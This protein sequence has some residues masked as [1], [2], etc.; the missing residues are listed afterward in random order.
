MLVKSRSQRATAELFIAH[1]ERS[2]EKYH[3]S[4][5][6]REALIK[7]SSFDTLTLA[8]SSEHFYFTY[9]TKLLSNVCQVNI[10]NV[11]TIVDGLISIFSPV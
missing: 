1:R 3:L 5:G 6:R 10:V 2:A 7:Y 11:H 8:T 4:R 9:R